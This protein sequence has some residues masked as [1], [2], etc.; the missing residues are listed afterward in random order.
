MFKETIISF[1]LCV[2]AVA[3]VTHDEAMI[4]NK[5]FDKNAIVPASEMIAIFERHPEWKKDLPSTMKKLQKSAESTIHYLE[6]NAILNFFAKNT[7]VT[8]DGWVAY[9][10][11]AKGELSKSDIRTMVSF[12]I[13]EGDLSISEQKRLGPIVEK[14]L[15]NAYTQRFVKLLYDN[16]LEAAQAF[17]GLM[18]RTGKVSFQISDLYTCAKVL[19]KKYEPTAKE[20][21]IVRG[22]YNKSNL[23]AIV[24]M[25]A[26]LKKKMVSE[27]YKI[28]VD[29]EEF[30]SK[31]PS[32][33]AFD[34]FRLY[35]ARD[36][37]QR[38]NSMRARGAGS[39]KMYAMAAKILEGASFSPSSNPSD[40][41]S[42]CRILAVLYMWG[43][44][45]ID[46]AID[47]FSRT[48]VEMSALSEPFVARFESMIQFFKALCFEKVGRDPTPCLKKSSRHP[49]CFYGQLAA[50]RLGR[51]LPIRFCSHARSGSLMSSNS[52]RE[53]MKLGS[54]L[55][56]LSVSSG[57]KNI[58]V[59]LDDFAKIVKTPSD[60]SLLL[61]L[62]KSVSK[63]D[64]TFFAK[65]MSCSEDSVFPEAY[66]TIA[67]E[68][69]SAPKELL[70]S[71]IL[72]ETAF[73]PTL[74]SCAGAQGLMQLLP[75]VAKRNAQRIGIEYIPSKIFDPKYNI[76]L[77]ST[78]TYDL[79]R[80][81]HGRIIPLA[82]SY[83]AGI[84]KLRE[85]A[86]EIPKAESFEDTLFWIESIPYEE[87]RNYVRYI[88]E[89]MNVYRFIMKKPFGSHNF[90]KAGN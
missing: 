9:Y 62:I 31:S 47:F 63:H 29:N 48:E 46:A 41:V 5:S 67:I 57:G 81:F 12:W 49:F 14:F 42:S 1:L 82:I 58:R 83:N 64:I 88:I 61:S 75:H 24:L 6:R 60:K 74:T 84:D 87:T 4:I 38:G 27:A 13:D 23:F 21:A 39:K 8:V 90:F 79:L 89:N 73:N 66:P 59:F 3:S 19:V 17:A 7:P 77:G 70:F 68:G 54:M 2:S 72:A 16:H 65:K 86:A 50:L 33:H 53:I 20:I 18:V 40:W 10:N 56:D 34:K 44:G 80:E 35:I 36:M 71:I 26:L 15:K 55:R 51:K 25:K 52:L 85:W 28:F 43:L 32:H 30:F 45:D 22:L 11:A 76:A 69:A 37:L 78:E